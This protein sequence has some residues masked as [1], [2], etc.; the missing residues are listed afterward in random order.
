MG[1][2][3]RDLDVDL[4]P[5]EKQP[6]ETEEAWAAFQAWKESA[7]RRVADHGPN[8]YTWSSQWS[9]GYRAYRYD[10]YMARVDEEAMVRYRLRMNDR[11]RRTAGLVQQ[12]VVEWLMAADFTRMGTAEVAKWWD[13]AVRVERDAAGVNALNGPGGVEPDWSDVEPVHTSQTLAERLG[14]GPV[15]A[16]ELAE[17]VHKAHSLVNGRSNGV[18]RD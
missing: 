4:N 16:A 10:L 17:K 5:W 9:W 1:K 8:A 7:D 15:E 2:N 14:L 13:L 6:D 18:A 11:Q 3:A 12:K